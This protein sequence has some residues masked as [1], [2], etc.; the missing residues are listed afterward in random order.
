MELV[1]PA[2]SFNIW[3][4]GYDGLMLAKELESRSV[5][6]RRGRSRY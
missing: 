2:V 1:G 5:G 3:C 4:G 6:M